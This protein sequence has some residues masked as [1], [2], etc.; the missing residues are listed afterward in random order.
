[1]SRTM[2]LTSVVL[3]ALVTLAA[4]GQVV[5]AQPAGRSFAWFAEFVS[6]DPAAHVVTVRAPIQ[7]A[8]ARYID[9]FDAGDRIV[10]TWTQFEGEG[11]AVMYVA[12]P[13]EMA[14]VS[15]GFIVPAEFVTVDIAAGTLTFATQVPDG[16]AQTLSST[17]PGTWIKVSAPMRQPGP[18]A[19]ITSVALNETP[20]P[21]PEPEPEI[22]IPADPNAPLADVAGTWTLD[23]SL[24]GNTLAF[25][26]TMVQDET[27]LTGTCVSQIGS[28][29]LTGQVAGNTVKFQYA[30]SFAGNPPF[31]FA[32]SGAIDEAGKMI[33]GVV[34][35]FDSESPFTATKK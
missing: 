32:F 10:V 8:V 19:T 9:T 23:A 35:V 16:V 30:L 7:S 14:S 17:E 33:K 11:D 21:R 24:A 1:M 34:S 26:C 18:A 5:L 27:E 3:A 2:I 20:K 22:E 28:A 15:S 4:H 12:S 13:E 6:L 31:D 29:E 25:D